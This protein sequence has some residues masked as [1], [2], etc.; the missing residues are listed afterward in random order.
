MAPSFCPETAQM[1]HILQPIAKYRHPLTQDSLD[2]FRQSGGPPIRI[3]Q[4]TGSSEITRA[5]C[6][7]A[8]RGI[9]SINE[10]HDRGAHDAGA[11]LWLDADIVFSP[12]LINE[13]YR[14]VRELDIPIAGIYPQR[15]KPA[16]AATNY[17][18]ELEFK[19]RKL[20]PVVS[21]MGALMIPAWLFA[22]QFHSSPKCNDENMGRIIC[23]TELR[24]Y[25]GEDGLTMISEDY[26]Y[27]LSFFE[28]DLG[29]QLKGVYSMVPALNYGHVAEKVL[30]NEETP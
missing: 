6:F 25:T 28:R 9:D 18:P 14:L 11:V 27:C 12:A 19:G 29:A 30:V 7:C 3:I 2:Q 13:H 24:Q 10:M 26:S 1:I 22:R 16:L 23:N 4:V 5:R 8:K 21:G 20:R 17:G 15:I